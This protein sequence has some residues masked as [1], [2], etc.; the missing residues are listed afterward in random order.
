MASFWRAGWLYFE[1]VRKPSK[2]LWENGFFRIAFYVI[3]LNDMKKL[4]IEERRKGIFYIWRKNFTNRDLGQ[5]WEYVLLSV[6]SISGRT[7]PGST[8][9]PAHPDRWR[10]TP[11]WWC[12]RQGSVAC[13]SWWS[14]MPLREDGKGDLLMGFRFFLCICYWESRRS[15][16]G[17][18]HAERRN[19][20]IEW[21]SYKNRLFTV[22]LWIIEEF[23]S[24]VWRHTLQSKSRLHIFNKLWIGIS[25]TVLLSAVIM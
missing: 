1:I 9:T 5:T 11:T 17:Q 3:L 18:G 12:C 15:I 23:N 21:E 22:F 7:T 4:F 13:R 16:K 20:N 19:Q 2:T 24:K 10:D 6:G 25:N 14:W 8:G